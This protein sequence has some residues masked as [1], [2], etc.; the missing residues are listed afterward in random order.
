MR[1]L[2][3]DPG[4]RHTS[5]LRPQSLLF[6]CSGNAIRSPMAEGIARH[7]L[8]RDIYVASAGVRPSE[9]D[10]FAA[11]VMDEIGLSLARHKPHTFEDLED[12]MFDVILTLSPEAHHWALEMTRTMAVEVSYWPT[13]DPTAV[14]GTRDQKLAAYRE[15]RDL[16]WK[17]IR[18]TFGQGRMGTV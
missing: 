11:A 18:D 3:P 16:L 7:L 1:S 2:P 4:S 13:P 8:G 6:A 9:P 15:V 5:I 12:A 10:P 14:F 17:R